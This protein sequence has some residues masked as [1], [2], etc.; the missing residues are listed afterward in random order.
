MHVF[1]AKVEQGYVLC[2][3]ASAYTTS[4][5]YFL[6]SVWYIFHIFVFFLKDLKMTPKYSV[7]CLNAKK[8][9]MC[10]KEKKKHVLGKLH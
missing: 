1:P 8:L 4:Q 6:R 10:L 9:L 3:L 5:V 7:Y 2:L